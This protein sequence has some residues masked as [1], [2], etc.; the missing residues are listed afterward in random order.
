MSVAP[1]RLTRLE[2]CQLAT[3]ESLELDLP[4]G[5][6]AFTGETGAGKSIIVDALGL[7]LGGRASANLIRSGAPDLLVIAFWDENSASRRLSAA[8]RS[9]A[10]RDGEVVSLR[11][12][13]EAVSE[14]LTVHWQHSAQSLLTASRQRAFLDSQV[15]EAPVRYAAAYRRWVAARERLKSL[16]EAEQSR[17][18]T[19][20]LLRF[21][22]QELAGAA[23]QEGEEEPLRQEL[24]R[25]SHVEAIAQGASQALE[26]LSEGE[27][28]AAGLLGEAIRAL[29]T[30]ARYD[31][32]AAQLLAE[33]RAPTPPSWPSN[34]GA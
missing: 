32:A 6:V 5:F 11:E 27:V 18:R 33:D 9:T 26:V 2:I 20:D 15:A 19:L 23:L 8:G 17:A 28:S 12:L 22:V 25:L 24:Q 3:I 7:L 10:R 29:N 14:R 4:G 13:G 34:W 16:R 31:E 30:S 21:Q 1:S